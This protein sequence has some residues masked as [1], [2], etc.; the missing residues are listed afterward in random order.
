MAHKILTVKV[1]PRSSINKIV[2]R[3]DDYLR[4][5]LTAP[6]VDNEANFALIDFLAQE[7]KVSRSQ[8][9]IISGAKSKT[10][11]IKVENYD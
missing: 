6:P 10:K 1:V 5:K 4:V 9:C 11:K 7:L 8:I 2:E 3:K